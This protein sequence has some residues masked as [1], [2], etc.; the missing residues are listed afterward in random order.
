ML[1]QNLRLAGELTRAATL[2]ELNR[3]RAIEILGE[4]HPTTWV[5]INNL[6]TVYADLGQF[7]QSLEL[8]EQIVDK[9]REK[10]GPQHRHTLLAMHNQGMSLY[11]LARD[12]EALA[13]FSETLQRSIDARGAKNPQTLETRYG[14]GSVL[15]AMQKW[16]EAIG[17]LDDTTK[18]MQ[19]VLG[20]DHPVTLEAVITL[21]RSYNGAER[22]EEAVQVLESAHATMIDTLG[23]VQPAYVALRGVVGFQL[24]GPGTTRARSHTTGT[25]RLCRA[26]AIG[27]TPQ[28]DVYRSHELRNS[29][30]AKQRTRTRRARVARTAAGLAGDG[31]LGHLSADQ[32]SDAVYSG[33]STDDSGTIPRIRT[34]AVGSAPPPGITA[35]SP[36]RHGQAS[37]ACPRRSCAAVRGLGQTGYSG[38]V[39]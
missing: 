13:V 24:P 26:G 33:R 31:Q 32:V 37:P 38:R 4:D 11:N 35:E 27:T 19:G 23:S 36:G 10:L 14:L 12:D 34:D 9:R 20:P 39:A 5:T 21:G 28:H 7:E 18:D 6:A 29:I 25:K 15:W 2:S 17:V 8:M 1:A 22:F 16:D 30:V 3:E